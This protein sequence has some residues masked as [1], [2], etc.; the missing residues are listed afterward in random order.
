M[1]EAHARGGQTVNVRRLVDSAAVGADGM[2]RMVIAHD[3]ENIGPRPR[4][5]ASRQE[6]TNQG[7]AQR[8]PQPAL[9]TKTQVHWHKQ[10]AAAA[11]P[12]AAST[13]SLKTRLRSETEFFQPSESAGNN[14]LEAEKIKKSVMFGMI[15]YDLV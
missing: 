3:E 7:R 11:L 15:W 12:Q 2:S 9:A 5:G 4:I 14:L 13:N 1:L 8:R 10:Y 6:R